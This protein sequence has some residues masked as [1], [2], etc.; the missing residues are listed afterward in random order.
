MIYL[1]LLY[2]N[3]DL[4]YAL[5]GNTGIFQSNIQELTVGGEGCMWKKKMPQ[6]VKMDHSSILA[7]YSGTSIKGLSE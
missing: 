1:T 5:V 2:K 7:G 6:K 4:L 3:V